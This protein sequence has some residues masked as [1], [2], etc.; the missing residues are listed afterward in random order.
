MTVREFLRVHQAT[1]R[2][3]G[4]AA[5]SVGLLSVSSAETVQA[6]RSIAAYFLGLT[7]Q[8][9]HR[10]VAYPSDIAGRLMAAV[11]AT[12]ENERLRDLAKRMHV[13]KIRAEQLEQD[14]ARM[15]AV[16]GTRPTGM[17]RLLNARVQRREPHQ[18]FNTLI[19]AR[20]KRDGIVPDAPVL[21][22]RCM[23]SVQIIGRI[24]SVEE[25]TARVLLITDPLSGIPVGIAGKTA[26]GV[27][28]GNGTP[29]PTIEYLLPESDVAPGDRVVTV[30][31]PPGIMTGN[32]DVGS[33]VSVELSPRTGFK[34]ARVTL[35]GNI[36]VLDHVLVLVP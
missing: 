21:T 24:W 26:Q 29:E 9:V 13:Y 35:A 6:F 15:R 3:L 27:L 18:W 12:D 19:I 32:L 11:Y 36:S 20:G 16:L 34:S 17:G 10:V 14:H 2:Y 25:E 23:E 31:L 33:V 5:V 8:P 30:T 22:D 7:Q 4:C 28:L 1:V